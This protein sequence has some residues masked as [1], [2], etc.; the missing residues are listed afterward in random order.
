[1]SRKKYLFAGSNPGGE[2]AAAIYTLLGTAKLNGFDPELYL[3]HVLEWVADH[4]INLIYELLPWNLSTRL[5]PT[6][7]RKRLCHRNC[8]SY[9]S[10]PRFR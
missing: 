4:P 5:I 10:I 1:M 6:I 8:S 3:C 9:Q 7:R 2:R